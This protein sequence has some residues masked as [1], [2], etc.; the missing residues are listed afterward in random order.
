MRGGSE[1]LVVIAKDGLR[2]EEENVKESRAGGCGDEEIRVL[3]E[4]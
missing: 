4:V 1:G 2:E 3:S